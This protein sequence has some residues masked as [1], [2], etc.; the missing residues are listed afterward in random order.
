MCASALEG[1]TSNAVLAAATLR[2]A[3]AQRRVKAVDAESEGAMIFLTGQGK[4]R[5]KD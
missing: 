2:T 3:H 5:E 1:L 4:A